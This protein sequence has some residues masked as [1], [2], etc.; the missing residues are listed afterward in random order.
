MRTWRSIAAMARE[1]D[2]DPPDGRMASS[3]IPPPLPQGAVVIVF[4]VVFVFGGRW[5]SR[6]GFPIAAV[7]RRRGP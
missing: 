6:G 5:A 4:V 1:W 2:S 3:D 7:L